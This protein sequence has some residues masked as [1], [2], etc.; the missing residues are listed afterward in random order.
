MENNT[1]CCRVAS[2]FG[3]IKCNMCERDSICVHGYRQRFAS[4]SHVYLR[5]SKAR[6]THTGNTNTQAGRHNTFT[7]CIQ[8][9]FGW[10]ATIVVF[11]VVFI[12]FQQIYASFCVCMFHMHV[13]VHICRCICVVVWALSNS[14]RKHK[15]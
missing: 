6:S 14:K 3:L 13:Y 11:V 2:Y 10:G 7:S 4:Y 8:F 5:R 12:S 15:L 9:Y 1:T